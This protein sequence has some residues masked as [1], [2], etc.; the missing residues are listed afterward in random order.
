MR[1]KRIAATATLGLFVF[2]IMGFPATPIL[3]ADNP[4]V[5]ENQLTGSNGWRLGGL[6]S[7][8]TTG[9]IKGY[10]SA[11]SV[12]QGESLTFSVTVNPAQTYTIDIYRIGWYGG[13]GGRLVRQ[14]GSLAGVTQAPCTPDPT[15]GLVACGW[16]PSYTFS[17][18][19]D[20]TSG[21]YLGLLTNAAG[22]Q[23]Y[24]SFIVKDGRPAAFLYQEGVNTDQAYNNYPD[25]GING[26]SLYDYNSYGA[27]TIVGSKRAAKVSFDRPYTGDG[28]MFFRTWDIYLIRWLERNG[29]DVTYTTDVDTH[30]NGLALQGHKAFISGGH[31]E[32]WT[33]EMYDAAEA[34][35]DHGVNLAFFGS[36]AVY[37]QVRYESSAAGVADR[38]IVCYKD[39]GLDPVQGA[40]TT[41]L[42]R[43][44]PLNR[45]EQTLVGVQ[46]TS[47][48]DWGK[49]VPYVVTN[50]GHWIYQGTGFKDG[51][52][53]P[54]IVG[55][56]M[57]RLWSGYPQPNALSQTLLGNSPFTYGSG[58]TDYAN[59][60]LYQ[61]PSGAWVFASGTSSWDWGLDNVDNNL[62]DPRIQRTTANLLNAF[63]NGAPQVHDFKIT[64]PASAT[65]GQSFSFTVTAEDSQGNPATWYAGT[66]H[67]TSTDSSSGV[68]LPANATLAG[69]Q[70][71]FSATLIKAGTQTVTA[72]DTVTAGITGSQSV[73]VK[74]AAAATLG[75]TAPSS[76]TVNQPFNVTVTLKDRFGNVATGYTGTVHFT[77]TDISPLATVPADYSFSAA[78]A[79]THAF[80]V[81]LETPPSQSVTAADKANASLTATAQ[82][83]VNLPLPPLGVKTP[84]F[85]LTPLPPQAGP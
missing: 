85:P 79:G 75:M 67:F 26:K 52:T 42:W 72:T 50:S 35:R 44:G 9:Q 53:V 34:A 32:Y 33:K 62:M 16:T 6:V 77:T 24:V 68:V 11:T 37:W 3:A 40:T 47:G 65:A 73:A 71:T 21:A 38:V 25:D 61:A 78:D 63:I 8:D 30:A 69:G 20:W 23:N 1:T 84:A 19:T 10:A 31:D 39:P 41:T 56:E 29:Y 27:N 74:A 51:D 80:S 49:N 18:P 55:Y 60:S 76:A 13:L 83:A 57:D 82:I 58:T 17:V 36:N 14:S 59:A 64:G 66:V 12:N 54:G 48:V 81:T 22:Y 2:S 46:Y 43:D 4:I 45:P 15:T 70:G 5:T 28:D 7:D